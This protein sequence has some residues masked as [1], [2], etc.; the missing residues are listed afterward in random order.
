MTDNTKSAELADESR[1]YLKWWTSF[2]V[3]R[4]KSML[5]TAFRDLDSTHELVKMA[6][7]AGQQAAPEA[8]AP[9]ASAR[10]REAMYL[11]TNAL[12]VLD[13]EYR[14]LA[15]ETRQFLNKASTTQPDAIAAAGVPEKPFAGPG[16]WFSVTVLGTPMR[17]YAPGKWESALWPSDAAA[18]VMQPVDERALFEQTLGA[19]IQATQGEFALSRAYS[20]GRPYTFSAT[21]WAWAGWQACAALSAGPAKAVEP[22]YSAQVIERAAEMLEGYVAYLYRVK[23]AEI[24]EHPYIPSVEEVA[25]ELRALIKPAPAGTEPTQAA[26]DVLGDD[27]I[28]AVI[29]HIAD[30]WPMKK[31]ALEEI[32]IKLRAEIER[33]DRASAKEGGA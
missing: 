25:E 7:E 32:E 3:D 14:S 30:N 19:K 13:R 22:T 4:R 29:D 26:R 28:N 5:L 20:D 12:P 11:L 24:E 10:M 23:P 31:Y 27:A 6:Y 15:L 16:M 17:E 18:G 8:P 2:E 1:S 21:I 9:T 33:I